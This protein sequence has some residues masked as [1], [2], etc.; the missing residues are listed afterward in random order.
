MYPL[1]PFAHIEIIETYAFLFQN[2]SA[3]MSGWLK[4]DQPSALS[5]IIHIL[6]TM[7]KCFEDGNK[8]AKPDTVTIN[9][10]MAAYAKAR[11]DGAIEI[12]MKV[13]SSLESKYGVKP[14]LLSY[15]I[16]VDSWCKSGRKDSPEQVME[17]LNAMENDF[18]EGNIDHKPDG[19]T[20]SSVIGCFT[21]FGRPDAAEKGE[22][23]LKRMKDLYKNF[24]GEPAAA[25]SVYNALMNAWASSRSLGSSKRV[26]QLLDEMEENHAIDP[27][28]PAPTRITYNTVIK[29]MRDGTGDDAAF[30]EKMLYLLESKGV[31]DRHFLPDTYTYTSVISA[32]GRSKAEN[33]AEK[34]LEIIERMLLATQNGN[35]G[36][37]PTVHSFNAALNSCAFA[38]GNDEAKEAAFHIAMKVYELLRVHDDPDHTTYG[39]LLRACSVLL[40]ADKKRKEEMVD[41]LFGEAC[42]RGCV[43]RLVLTQMQFAA[44]PEQY[45]RLVGRDQ[46]DMITARDVPRSWRQNVREKAQGP[47]T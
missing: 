10:V 28:I 23:L 33:K 18:K 15:N 12:A 30:A 13:R 3:A 34:A 36:A 14:D 25:S 24:G 26:K 6:E 39:T 22:E 17:I 2:P 32:Y 29:A 35:I 11:D 20:Y 45:L 41:K 21:K 19:Y 37:N 42:L 27:L 38:L 40:A 31:N 8:R 9:T 16:I 1:S 47:V 7:E 43:G 44:S 5:K 4:S 46:A